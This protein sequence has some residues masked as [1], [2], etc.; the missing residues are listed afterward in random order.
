MAIPLRP[1][2]VPNDLICAICLSVPLEPVIVNKCT[3]VFCEDCIAENFHHQQCNG[4]DESCPV[5]RVDCTL[6]DMLMLGDESPLSYRIW[7]S[8][9]VKCEHHAEGCEWTG[10]IVDY[11]S[12]MCSCQQT[13]QQRDRDKEIISSLKKENQQLKVKNKFLDIK[14]QELEVRH[15]HQNFTTVN[16]ELENIRAMVL[17]S[18]EMSA[19][20]GRG[21]YAYNCKNVVQL[22]KLICQNLENKPAKINSNKIFECVKNIGSDLRQEYSDEPEYFFIDTRMLMGVCLASAWFTENQLAR[23]REISAEYGWV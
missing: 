15:R 6:D 4:Q 23:I 21:R 7:S 19:T 1:E 14:N 18:I 16:R 3:H 5:C 8:I 13:I 2:E 20:N 10:S 17:A 22:T 12:H 9:A 11:R